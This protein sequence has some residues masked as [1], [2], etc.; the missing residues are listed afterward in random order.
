MQKRKGKS[1]K[2]CGRAAAEDGA[3]REPRYT[4]WPSLGNKQLTCSLSH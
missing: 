3:A 4:S 2:G 1:I